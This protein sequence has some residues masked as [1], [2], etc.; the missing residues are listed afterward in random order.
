VSVAA[1]M[2]LSVS[3]YTADTATGLRCDCGGA[4]AMPLSAVSFSSC[5][6]SS[7]CSFRVRR[8]TVAPDHTQ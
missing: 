7:T 3:V 2:P 5:Q 1:A 4:V 6:I 8:V